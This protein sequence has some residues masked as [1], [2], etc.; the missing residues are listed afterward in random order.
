MPPKKQSKSK[1][2]KKEVVV[3]ET[4]SKKKTVQVKEVKAKVESK[5]TSN[6]SQ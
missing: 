5:R 6:R 2:T 1:S 4:A 3:K